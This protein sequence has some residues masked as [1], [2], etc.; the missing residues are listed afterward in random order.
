MM[1]L[2]KNVLL[3]VIL[4]KRL[5]GHKNEAIKKFRCEHI[6]KI[7]FKDLLNVVFKDLLVYSMRIL[8]KRHF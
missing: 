8:K 5:I 4:N 7:I 3:N 6:N 1:Q 2:K